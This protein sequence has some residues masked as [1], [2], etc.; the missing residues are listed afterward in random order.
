[1]SKP[2][3]VFGKQKGQ[4]QAY[5]AKA[6]DTDVRRAALQPIQAL[7]CLLRENGKVIR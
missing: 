6:D 7:L 2:E 4:R 1:M 5:I 3:A